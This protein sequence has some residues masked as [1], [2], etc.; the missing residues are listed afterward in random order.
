M[1]KTEKATT[2]TT[3]AKTKIKKDRTI[4]TIYSLTKL[5]RLC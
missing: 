1:K 5:F 4:T 2:K 3:N